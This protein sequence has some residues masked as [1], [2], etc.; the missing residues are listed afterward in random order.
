MLVG[1][2]Y[3]CSSGKGSSALEPVEADADAE[4]VNVLLCA[5]TER[6]TRTSDALLILGKQT[7][8]PR[9]F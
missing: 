2:A 4:E 6:K 7:D 1:P 8:N 3:G 9:L 5:C